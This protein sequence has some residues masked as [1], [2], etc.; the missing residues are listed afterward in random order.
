M[1]AR[2][3]T[4]DVLISRRDAADRLGCHIRSIDYYLNT[5]K[6]TRYKDGRGRVG[7]D[8]EELDELIVFLRDAIPR[9]RTEDAVPGA[10]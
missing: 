4:P 7:I 2:T 9:L 6:L 1:H 3:V 8:P 10:A 5:R